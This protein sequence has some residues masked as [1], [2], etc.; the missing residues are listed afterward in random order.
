LAGLELFFGK[1]HAELGQNAW[2][3]GDVSFATGEYRLCLNGMKVVILTGSV[4]RSAGGFFTSVRRLSQSLAAL[5]NTQVNVAA[6]KD[7][8]G[9]ADSAAWNPLLPECFSVRGPASFGFSPEL[10]RRLMQSDCDLVH[11]HGIWQFM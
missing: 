8:F 3:R 1:A 7:E 5:S 2:R 9:E 10:G 4:S 6:L 11:Q